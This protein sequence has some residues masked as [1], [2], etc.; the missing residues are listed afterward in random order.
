MEFSRSSYI[1]SFRNMKK[2]LKKILIFSIPFALYFI[3]VLIVD[4]YNYYQKNKIINTDLKE[5]IAS[6]VEPHLYKMIKFENDPKR[7]ILLGDSR[8]NR[9][10]ERIRE[11]SDKYA[12][13]AYGA[14]SLNEILTTFEWIKES[15]ISLDTIVLGLNFN[16]YNKYNKRTWVE[17]TIERKK[18]VF[19]YGF[20]S[21]AA[22]S[23]FLILKSLLV[24]V[25]D[26]IGRPRVSK[27]EFWKQ[28]VNNYGSKFYKR[29]GYPKNYIERL[30]Q[31]SEYCKSNNI[32]LI[33]WVPPCSDEL[34][35][36]VNQYKLSSQRERFYNDLKELGTFYNFNINTSLTNNRDNFTDPAHFNNET[37]NYICEII[38]GTKQQ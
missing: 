10:Y 20:S 36:I 3:M 33:I 21:Y 4:P 9:L 14:G 22:K 25:K 1:F 26:D 32:E 31:M 7:N 29:Y 5:D 34:N 27:E 6:K 12:S 24:G 13:L 35:D 37:G 18:N 17:E 23:S 2:L 38:F 30:K 11:K 19:S 8:S 16:L 15:R 28:S